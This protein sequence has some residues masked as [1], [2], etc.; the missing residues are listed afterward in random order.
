[1]PKRACIACGVLTDGSYCYRCDPD[2]ERRRNTPGRTTKAQKQFR[3][4]VLQRAGFQC[5]AV[6]DGVRCTATTGLEAHHLTKLR[7]AT[8]FDPAGGRCLCRSHHRLADLDAAA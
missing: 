7:A 5:E 2:R 1:M 3:A 6:I 8:S 4:A